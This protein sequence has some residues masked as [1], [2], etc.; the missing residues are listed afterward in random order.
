MGI[1]VQMASVLSLSSVLED[2]KE[3]YSVASSIPGEEGQHA[4]P[5]QRRA[6]TA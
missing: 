6:L 3:S 1:L 2:E 4:D 5:L